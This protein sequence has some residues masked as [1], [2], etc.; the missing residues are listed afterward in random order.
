VVFE[1]DALQPWIAP[2][3]FFRLHKYFEQPLL[4]DPIDPAYE[5][6]MVL[7][8]RFEDE[9]PAFQE[10]VRFRA[11]VAQI[12]PGQLMEFPLHIERADVLAILEL[13][14]PL[15]SRIARDVARALDGVGQNKI[16]RQTAILQQRQDARSRADLQGGGKRAHVGVADEQMKPPIFSVIGQ[17]LIPSVDDGAIELYPLIDVVHDV[18]GPL[19]KLELDL[20]FRLRWLEIE[21]QW[22]GLADPTGPGKYLPCRQKSKQRSEYW[23]RELRLPSHQIVLVA[24]EGGAGM[25]IDI[26][27][28]E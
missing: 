23:R 4:G 2:R 27:F 22:I 17:R 19:A 8:Q 3:Q 28:D 10:P 16:P 21:R 9:T 25:M 13:D 11:A 1:I 7:R 26:V 14:N 12:F 15:L 5:R 18:V 24:P 20:P 6:L